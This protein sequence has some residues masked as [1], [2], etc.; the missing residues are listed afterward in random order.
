MQKSCQ[1]IVDS[2]IKHCKLFYYW[3]KVFWAIF[4]AKDIIIIKVAKWKILFQT[5]KKWIFSYS[6]RL[7]WRF[8]FVEEFFLLFLHLHFFRIPAWIVV[9]L[10]QFW[11][12]LSCCWRFPSAKWHFTLWA[13]SRVWICME[14]IVSW[15]CRF[16]RCFQIVQFC[17]C[18]WEWNRLG[19]DWWL[20]YLQWIWS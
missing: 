19:I 11:H 13:N 8:F 7:G 3:C 9:E 5:N 20:C 10:Q 15:G 6:L 4:K 14:R 12:W 2:W 16:W 18:M 17:S 1:F